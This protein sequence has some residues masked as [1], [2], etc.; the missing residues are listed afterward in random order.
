MHAMAPGTW[1]GPRNSGHLK[2]TV[3]LTSTSPPAEVAY[4]G[5]SYMEELYLFFFFGLADICTIFQ[6]TP[7]SHNIVGEE[8]DINVK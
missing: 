7:Q 8:R 5:G 3:V 4:K 2:H 6:V 1:Q